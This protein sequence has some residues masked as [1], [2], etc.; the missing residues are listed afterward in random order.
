VIDGINGIPDAT[1]HHWPGVLPPGFGERRW[2]Y[3][4][5]AMI[6]GPVYKP[7]GSN[8]AMMCARQS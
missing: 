3:F 4:N 6:Y 7:G 2:W 1:V 5:A 8:A